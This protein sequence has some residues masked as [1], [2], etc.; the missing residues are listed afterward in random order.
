MVHGSSPSSLCRGRSGQNADGLVN[1]ASYFGFVTHVGAYEFG[2]S[3]EFAEFRDELLTFRFASASDNEMRAFLREGQC[4][5]T[6][7]AREARQ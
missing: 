3:A 5:G 1:E 7:D 6:P 2:R 4:G